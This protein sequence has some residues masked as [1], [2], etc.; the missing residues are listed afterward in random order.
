MSFNEPESVM[1]DTHSHL[2]TE[3]F[4]E[5]LPQVIERAKSAGVSKIFMPNIDDT[6]IDALLEVCDAYKGYC[7][8][9]LGFHP[10]SVERDYK[11]RLALVKSRLFEG[12]SFVA[13]GEVGMDLYWDKTYCREQQAVLDKQICWALEC[14][15]PLVIHCRDAF[16]ELFEVLSPYK[17]TKVGGIFHSFTGT[18]EDAERLLDYPHFMLGINGVVTFKKSTLPE[19]LKTIP[20]ERIVLETDSPYLAPVPYRGKRNETSYIK[21][22]AMKLAE[23]YA[24][25]LQKVDAVTSYNALKVFKMSE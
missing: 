14:D 13:I 23:V 7:Y 17:D 3:E 21:E 25:D 19:V 12:H 20:L 16:P 11:P 6:T 10:T 5:D 1:I 15:L 8:P 4:V 22:V 18:A 24:I 2:F 9:M